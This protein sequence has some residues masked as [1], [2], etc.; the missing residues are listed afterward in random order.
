MNQLQ[1]GMTVLIET[2]RRVFL[3][4]TDVLKA[5]WKQKKT[6]QPSTLTEGLVQRKSY[7]TKVAIRLKTRVMASKIATSP[8]VT[9]ICAMEP[10]YQWPVVSY[11]WHALLQFLSVN[12]FVKRIVTSSVK[13]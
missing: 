4:L 3:A 1:I 9:K 11:S 2:K 6:A 7:A 12:F 5:M 10:R 8:A 13:A